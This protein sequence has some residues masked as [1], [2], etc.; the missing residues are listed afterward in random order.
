MPSLGPHA[1][2]PKP[3][4]HQTVSPLS[5]FINNLK[6]VNDR[7]AHWSIVLLQDTDANVLLDNINLAGWTKLPNLLNYLS[8]EI[9]HPLSILDRRD[10][11]RT[12][13]ASISFC[14]Q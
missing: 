13:R 11:S 14:C 7:G 3:E 12:K 10:K 9:L 2:D 8:L 5:K 6:A 4:L 1:P